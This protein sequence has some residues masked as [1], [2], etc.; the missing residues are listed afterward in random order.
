[1]GK[2]M[3]GRVERESEQLKPAKE[4]EADGIHVEMVQLEPV[5]RSKFLTAWW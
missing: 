3:R 1:M 4:M 5:L 2:E